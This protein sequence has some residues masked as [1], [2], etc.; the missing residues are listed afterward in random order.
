MFMP[1]VQGAF[2]GVPDATVSYVTMATTSASGTPWDAGTLSFG[3]PAPNR[4][5]IV[6]THPG[7]SGY[8]TGVSIGGVTATPLIRER[9]I[10]H[11]TYTNEH[12]FWIASVPTGT[13]GNVTI[14]Y[15]GTHSTRNNLAIWAVYTEAVG[16]YHAA[17]TYPTTSTSP[18]SLDIDCPAGGVILAYHASSGYSSFAWTNLTEDFDALVVAHDYYTSGA[19]DAFADAQTN[20]TITLTGSGGAG[21]YNGFICISLGPEGGYTPDLTSSATMTASAAHGSFP[22]TNAVD[23]SSTTEWD[24]GSANTAA[25]AWIQATFASAKEIRNV[26][27]KH[28]SLNNTPQ[29]GI[30]VEYYNGSSWVTVETIVPERNATKQWFPIPASASSTQWR[31]RSLGA[32]TAS[33][34]WTIKDLEMME[35][36]SVV[37]IPQGTGSVIGNMTSGG[38]LS[39]AFDGV[40]AQSSAAGAA[41]GTGP[42]YCGKSWGSAKSVYMVK[43]WG[44]DN[45]GYEESGGGYGAHTITLTLEG[46]NDNSSWTS[47]GSTSFTDTGGTQ[48]KTFF[49]TPDPYSYH[50]LKIESSNTTSIR[51][52]EVEFWELTT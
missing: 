26:A 22:V 42:G 41:I 27:I 46:S 6:A 50:R 43:T 30:A 51:L 18:Q 21:M 13:S 17:M 31:L 10:N 4:K 7:S 45:Y 24:E 32:C 11:T 52:A 19:S 34:S 1:I 25:G 39:S 40:T 47:L 5:I 15:S 9:T 48:P 44:S 20:R 37:H 38:G 29:T 28:T 23:D 35:A 3:T 16:F 2:A 33:S 49:T 8:A 36:G 12:S 14:T